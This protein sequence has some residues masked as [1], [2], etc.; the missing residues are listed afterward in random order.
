[1]ICQHHLPSHVIYAIS[2]HFYQCSLD[3]EILQ[4]FKK[5]SSRLGAV[6]GDK[7]DTFTYM[8]HLAAMLLLGSIICRKRGKVDTFASQVS[9]SFNDSRDRLGAFPQH[10]FVAE[11]MLMSARV[12]R[13][14]WGN[15]VH[16]SVPSQSNR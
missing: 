3:T 2:L 11:I 12:S 5:R 7:E 15:C 6:V 13:V 16:C 10:T 1:M 8:Y 14:S 9:H 4:L